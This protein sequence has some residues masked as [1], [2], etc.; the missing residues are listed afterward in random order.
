M[1]TNPKRDYTPGVRAARA[2]LNAWIEQGGGVLSPTEARDVLKALETQAT[3]VGALGVIVTHP[4]N[5]EALEHARRAHE[6]CT[7]PFTFMPPAP[8]A[9]GVDDLV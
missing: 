7:K 1:S 2:L 9:G 6:L 5:P 3:A 8:S 4:G